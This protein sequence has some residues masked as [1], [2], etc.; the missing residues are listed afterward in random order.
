[1]DKF[2]KYDQVVSRRSGKRG[3][4]DKIEFDEFFHCIMYRVDM[5]S[6]RYTIDGKVYDGCYWWFKANDLQTPAEHN[7][8]RSVQAVV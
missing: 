1:M 7:A 3:F 4:I 5:G 8:E 6:E 2:K